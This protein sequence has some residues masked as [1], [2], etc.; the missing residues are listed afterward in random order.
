MCETFVWFTWQGLIDAAHFDP[1][2]HFTELNLTQHDFTCSYILYC[3]QRAQGR[4][5]V[6][7][8]NNSKLKLQL[9]GHNL[10]VGL[11]AQKTNKLIWE[12]CSIFWLTDFS[13]GDS[14]ELS[15]IQFT[16]PKRTR[17]RQ[18]SFVVSGVAMWISFKIHQLWIVTYGRV[19][20][21]F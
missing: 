14:L 17:H 3:Y 20:W 10:Q 18:D 21:H 15:G 8:Q 5:P 7:F 19:S 1:V 9:C 12:R 11:E 13:V 4:K 16:P 6:R 2:R